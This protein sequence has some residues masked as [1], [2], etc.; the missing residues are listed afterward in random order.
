[1]LFT[2]VEDAHVVLCRRGV[3][4]Q[5][6]VYRRGDRLYARVGNNKNIGLR[7]DHGTT[8]PK[9]WW[10][11]IDVAHEFERVSG[12]MMVQVVEPVLAPFPARPRNRKKLPLTMA[13]A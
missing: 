9:V 8:D 2:E 3:F 13:N 5:A 10:D 6:A 11:F 1:M 4:Q 7:R 12:A